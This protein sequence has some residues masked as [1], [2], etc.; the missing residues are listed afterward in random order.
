MFFKIIIFLIVVSLIARF[1][2]RFLMPIMQ[3]T[4]A[5]RQQ[6]QDMQQQMN[7]MNQRAEKPKP[8][9]RIDGEFIDYEEVK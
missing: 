9:Q 2:L 5:A 4:K 8:N 6:M 7:A 1:V 3:V